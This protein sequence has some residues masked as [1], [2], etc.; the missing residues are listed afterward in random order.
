MFECK[1]CKERERRIVELKIS[2]ANIVEAQERHLV[3]L[4]DEI[5]SLKLFLGTVQSSVL[6]TVSIDDS[7][8]IN[9]PATEEELEIEREAQSLLNGDY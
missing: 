2:H 9:P 6:P 5:K 4:Q 8:A 1:V 7:T 3:S